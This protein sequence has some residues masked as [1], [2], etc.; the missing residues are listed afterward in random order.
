MSGQ[1]TRKGMTMTVLWFILWTVIAVALVK[2]AFFPTN[3]DNHA[4]DELDPTGDYGELL[5]TPSVQTLTNSLKLSGT[6]KKSA[7]SALKATLDGEVVDFY[8]SSGDWVS[9]GEPV[10]QIRKAMQ[11]DDTVGT[12]PEGNPQVT[13][14]EK[15]WSYEDVLAPAD[16]QIT[17][18]V[19]SDQAVTIGQEVG[20]VQPKSYYAVAELTPEQ[21]YRL[22]E[23]PTEVK[24]AIK[25]GPAP[26]ACGTPQILT[27]DVEPGSDKETSTAIELRCAI[28]A[29]TTV[30]PGLQ[31]EMDIVAGSV[32]DA[33]TLPISAVEGRFATGYVYLPGAEG[34]EPVK[35]AV[36]LGL[37]T[38]RFVQITA[39][40]D[41][42]T[43]VLEF[44]PG[45][46]SEACVP[47]LENG[48]FCDES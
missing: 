15:W 41:A 23:V 5:V 12:D 30:F 29:E 25:D 11:D 32:A 16:G 27:P 13:P 22:Q 6:I 47:D 10:L 19:L 35:K 2:F 33:L 28:P 45:T 18:D 4:A 34:G 1:R 26:F 7:P 37:A 21:M 42:N 8:Y 17:F 14:G 36:E 20:S 31:V 39:G 44:I 3:T 24:V 46:S 38:D 9:A 40:I 43:E 48:V